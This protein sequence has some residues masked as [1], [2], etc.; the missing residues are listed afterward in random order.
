MTC[1]PLTVSSPVS[2]GPS[3]F[4]PVSMSMI[5]ASVSGHGRPMLPTLTVFIV[6]SS[7][8]QW[9]TGDDSVRP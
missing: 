1:G 9:V 2:S 7:G 3:S 6:L 8:L 5:L 4:W